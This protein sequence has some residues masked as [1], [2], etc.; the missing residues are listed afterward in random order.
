MNTTL[1]R[2]AVTDEDRYERHAIA[3]VSDSLRWEFAGRVPAQL[4]ELA[5][6]ESHARFDDATLREFVPVMV[7]RTAR[8]SLLAMVA[9][10]PVPAR[11][12]PH[13][14]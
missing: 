4:I 10:V 7:E 12:G 8:A 5:V 6:A 14:T 11:G 9:A 1:T 13:R 2:P 3:R